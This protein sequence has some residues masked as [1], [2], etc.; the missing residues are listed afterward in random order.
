MET[1]RRNEGR[2][3]GRCPLDS[4]CLLDEC[5][6]N[7][8]RQAG[9]SVRLP[10]ERAWR[11]LVPVMVA[12]GGLCG[13]AGGSRRQVVLMVDP[14]AV[15]EQMGP[16]AAEAR[17]EQQ[18]CRQHE[19]LERDLPVAEPRHA[20]EGSI[21]RTQRQKMTRRWADRTR[22]SASRLVSRSRSPPAPGAGRPPGR[23]GCGR[24]RSRRPDARSGRRGSSRRCPR[25]AAGRCR[26]PT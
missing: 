3:S 22:R 10:E 7:R 18:D 20:H 11:G 15:G 1:A 6:R 16:L 17:E 4:A 24:P 26:R 21:N 9:G 19:V 12:Q 5:L 8:E 23:A 25:A 14:V 2:G 13:R